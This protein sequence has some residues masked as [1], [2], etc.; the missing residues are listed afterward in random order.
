[1]IALPSKAEAAKILPSDNP[2]ALDLY[3]SVVL[4]A[5]KGANEQAATDEATAPFRAMFARVVGYLLLYPPSDQARAVVLSEVEHCRDEPQR[6]RDTNEAVYDLGEMYVMDFILP[7][8]ANTEDWTPRPSPPVSRASFQNIKEDAYRRGPCQG[9]VNR[10]RD[11]LEAQ[12]LALVRDDHRCMVT[13]MMDSNS[14]S[15]KLSDDW[16][17]PTARIARTDPCHIFPAVLGN[18][19]PAGRDGTTRE[20]YVAERLWHILERF[21]YGHLHDTLR[22]PKVHR[23]ENVLTLD[24]TLHA[25]FRGM[26]MWLEKAEGQPA[27][28]YR[29]AVSDPK[30][31]SFL[32]WFGLPHEVQL[33]AHADAL[34][35]PDP[36]YLHIH[37]AC[38]RIATLSGA[39]DYLF[40]AFAEAPSLDTTGKADRALKYLCYRLVHDNA[41]IAC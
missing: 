21:G 3:D 4:P 31:Y 36:A 33:V 23:L 25:A 12:A 38:C 27:N 9:R 34:P 20:D 11:N 18:T 17:R 2:I 8:Y 22:G 5:E 29:V 39:D 16:E 37:A 35:L 19:R 10:P 6:E 7:F 41:R 30:W 15:H 24:C 40:W 13:H 32:G 26:F 28:C 14:W 1:M